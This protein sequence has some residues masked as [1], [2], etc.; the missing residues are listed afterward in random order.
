MFWAPKEAAVG[1]FVEFF[2][3]GVLCLRGAWPAHGQ[4][5]SSRPRARHC[6]PYWAQPPEKVVHLA[7]SRVQP[8]RRG[9]ALH[10]FA[11]AVEPVVWFDDDVSLVSRQM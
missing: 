7:A 4:R 5:P 11:E 2:S 3:A 6:V 9:A 8:L 10:S 1:R